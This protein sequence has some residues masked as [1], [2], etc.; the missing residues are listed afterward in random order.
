MNV[1]IDNTSYRPS[2]HILEDKIYKW[3]MERDDF[4][5]IRGSSKLL[6]LKSKR[7]WW[8]LRS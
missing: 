8:N 3:N 7:R 6:L 2:Y 5:S 4:D 1:N